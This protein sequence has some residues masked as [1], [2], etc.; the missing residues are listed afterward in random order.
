M[1]R[2]AV[3]VTDAVPTGTPVSVAVPRHTFN[4]WKAGGF[5]CLK[6]LR[7]LHRYTILAQVAESLYGM[8]V[9][10]SDSR[11]A[12]Q[13]VTIKISSRALMAHH[14]S[15]HGGLVLE[16]LDNEARTL[17]HISTLTPPK[18]LTYVPVLPLVETLTDSAFHYLV[19]Q[20]LPG[21]DLGS[22]M[23]Q[24]F[25]NVG[26]SEQAARK[27]MTQLIVALQ[28][29]H[30]NGIAHCD[31]SLDN[32]CIDANDNLYLVDFGVC[33]RSVTP[34]NPVNRQP[35]MVQGLVRG[36][37]SYNSPELIQGLGWDTYANDVFHVGVLMFMLL[38]GSGPF[39]SATT[40]DQNFMKMQSGEWTSPVCRAQCTTYAR[41]G[42]TATD[43]IDQIIKPESMRITLAQVLRHP[44]F[45]STA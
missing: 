4:D 36:K 9:L 24:R 10:A 41:L 25:L 19:T 38:T 28:W 7:S 3:A 1:P 17:Q 20:F 8:V 45:A 34:A 29:L 16:D 5:A 42:A 39:F 43:L 22:M 37:F 27:Y 44:W 35:P 14:R 2:V 32:L 18:E 13:L 12:G 31:I 6:G 40:T 15:V 11:R 30:L 26:V 33:I 23:T 21:G